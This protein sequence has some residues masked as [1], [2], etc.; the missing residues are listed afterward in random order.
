MN[1]LR[2]MGLVRI[3]KMTPDGTKPGQFKV[4]PQT[5]DAW[6]TPTRESRKGCRCAG[7]CSKR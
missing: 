4:R 6:K 5:G 1:L 3:S 2:Q 7:F